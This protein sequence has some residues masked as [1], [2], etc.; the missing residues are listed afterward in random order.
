[1]I[2]RLTIKYSVFERKFYHIWKIA[3]KR[4]K[5]GNAILT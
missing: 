1:M 2:E 3:G 4:S 5:I